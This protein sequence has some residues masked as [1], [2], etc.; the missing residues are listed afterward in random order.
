MWYKGSYSNSKS[1]SMG[2][3]LIILYCQGRLIRNR[4]LDLMP[5]DLMRRVMWLIMLR[6]NKLLLIWIISFPL[7]LLGAV[8]LY[9]GSR[10]ESPTNPLIFSRIA[11]YLRTHLM[12]ISIKWRTIISILLSLISWIRSATLNKSSTHSLLTCYNTIMTFK[13]MSSI[14][15]S[16]FISNAKIAIMK[17]LI[18]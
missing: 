17:V 5:E 15:T 1:I 16:T 2:R 8:Y 7:L 13:I 4:E 11:L 14:I 12:P 6:L 3:R 10:M 9:S 18:N